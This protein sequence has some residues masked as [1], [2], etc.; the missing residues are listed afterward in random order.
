MQLEKL[1]TDG[2]TTLLLS[3]VASP[4]PD[5]ESYLGVTGDLN[6]DDIQL[7][8]KQNNSKYVRCDTPPGNY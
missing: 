3:Y 4:F 7:I 5:F 1:S 2:Y 6:E 8:L